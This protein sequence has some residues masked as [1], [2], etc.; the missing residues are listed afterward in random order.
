KTADPNALLGL[1]AQEELAVSGPK[2]AL[3][4][5]NRLGAGRAI[6]GTVI[7]MG[8]EIQINAT[9][10]SDPSTPELEVTAIAPDEEAMSGSIDE[11][12]R[13]F[14]FELIGFGEETGQSLASVTS[15]NYTALKYLLKAADIFRTGDYESAIDPLENAIAEDS[16][17][18]LAWGLLSQATG[19]L[20]REEEEAVAFGRAFALRASLPERARSL[21]EAGYIQFV[22]GDVERA[23]NVYRT[24]L[25][26]YPYDLN[27]IWFMGEMLFHYNPFLGKRQA[28]AR[29]YF[30]RSSSFGLYQAGSLIHLA[31]IARGNGRYAEADSLGSRLVALSGR[32]AAG[33]FQS[34]MEGLRHRA[35]GDSSW[36]YAGPGGLNFFEVVK[37]WRSAAMIFEDFDAARQIA[38]VSSRYDA[39]PTEIR[40]RASLWTGYSAI[41]QGRLREYGEIVNEVGPA[42]SGRGIVERA[43]LFAFPAYPA[44]DDLIS[45]VRADVAEWDTLT[46]PL[47]SPTGQNLHTG[48]YEVIKIYLDALLALRSGDTLALSDGKRRLAARADSTS[49]SD[50]AFSTLRTVEAIE[51]WYASDWEEVVKAIDEAR[52]RIPWRKATSSRIREQTLN[53]FVKAEALYRLGDLETALDHYYSV[54]ATDEVGGLLYVGPTYLRMAEIHERLGDQQKAIEYY[55]RLVRAWKNS[56]PELNPIRDEAQRNLD[57]LLAESVRE[58]SP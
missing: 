6:M 14:V 41:A 56:D 25:A 4:L 18:A 48:E 23:M 7:R 44:T 58:P 47:N 33:E 29:E 21:F 8:D 9:L 49:G 39:Y 36:R 12:A 42:F 5:A 51:A 45:A 43:L 31:E 11:L 10:Y 52:L 13:E 32:E 17:F 2:E 34:H 55:T 37:L 3:A 50:L 20:G 24:I 22:V 38:T 46:A 28:E 57:R 53:R 19:W 30:E 27:A 54:L 26:S 15:T 40:A 16:S 35:E 1:I